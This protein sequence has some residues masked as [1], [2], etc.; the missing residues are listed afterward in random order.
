[1]TARHVIAL[2]LVW[3]GVGIELVCCLGVLVLRDTLDRL[4]CAGA[5]GYGLLLVAV[6]VVVQESFSLIG[7]KALAMAALMLLAGP[8]LAHVTARTVRIRRRGR[9]ELGADEDVEVEQP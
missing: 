8:V 1:M 3:A 5:V 6:G 9:W 4:H 7:D 2:V